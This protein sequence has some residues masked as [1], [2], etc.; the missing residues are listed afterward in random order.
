MG[1]ILPLGRLVKIRRRLRAQGKR[2]VF[3]NGTFDIL[4]RGHVEYLAR[5][6]RLGDVLVVG[7]NTDA[8]IR[9][10]KGPRRPINR[11]ADRAAVLAG[12]ASVDFVC[13]FG[14]PTPLAMIERLLPDVLVK[15][16]DWRPGAIVGGD[17]VRRYGG[18]VRRIPL[19]RGRSTTS[20]IE[21]VLAA[22]GCNGGR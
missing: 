16:A 5:A 21:R 6:R 20:V 2:V 9:R 8:S 15:G 1:R 17:V 4:H 7:L 14:S 10:I 3:T 19:T 12:L 11:N 18:T 13:F 22:Y